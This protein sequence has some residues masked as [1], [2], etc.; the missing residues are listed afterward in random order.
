MKPSLLIIGCGDLGIRV[1]RALRGEGWRVGAV[2]RRP[3]LDAQDLEWHAADYCEAGALDFA[4][5]W[6]PDFVLA[7]FTPLGRDV[8]GYR[9]GFSG[10]ARHLLDG[11]GAHC[12]RHLFYVSSTRVY[13]ESA[14]GWVD[15]DSPLS[16][17]DERAL[18]I[19]DG[20]RRLLDS[21]IT[22]TL[23]RC[24]GIYGASPGRL[25]SKVSRGEIAPE[26]PIRFTNRIH[27]DDCTGFLLH[28]LKR[29]QQG[30]S[31][32]PVY[33]A[34]DDRPA[35]AHEVETWLATELGRGEQ[36]H[37]RPDTPGPVSHKRCRNTLLH[38]TGYRLRYPDYRAGYR[39]VLA[40]ARESG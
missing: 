18:A 11:L 2:R 1:G 8:E 39:A 13:A 37:S 33:N 24:G 27:R 6:A 35:P 31:L 17:T 5:A 23:V 28:L 34:V 36:A 26:I 30:K 40:A 38:N 25:I 21:G 16:T 14:G 29:A 19:I 20:E 9:A 7:T 4:A 15:E 12:P 10:A 32:A 22:A 3:P